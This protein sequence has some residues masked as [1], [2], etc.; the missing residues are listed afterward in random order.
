MVSNATFVPTRITSVR[1]RY[2]NDLVYSLE[3]DSGLIIA[4][5]LVTHNCRCTAQAVITATNRNRIK[6]KSPTPP[7][8]TPQPPKVVKQPAPRPTEDAGWSFDWDDLPDPEDRFDPE[9]YRELGTMIRE[10]IQAVAG[11]SEERFLSEVKR[12]LKSRGRTGAGVRVEYKVPRNSSVSRQTAKELSEDVDG[13]IPDDWVFLGNRRPVLVQETDQRAFYRSKTATVEVPVGRDKLGV[14]AGVRV[15]EYTHHLQ[16]QVDGLDNIF[17]Q[18]HYRRTRGEKLEEIY[19]GLGEYGRRDKYPRAYQGKEYFGEQPR[20]VLT[21]AMEA[22][23]RPTPKDL[24]AFD[25]MKL[26]RHNYTLGE[27]RDK[28]PEM[29]DLLLGVLFRYS[30]E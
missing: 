26:K 12:R 27:M 11:T 23:A 13:L 19:K 4:N 22:L 21:M 20:E 3:T 16:R 10:D 18:E 28:D 14:N 30:P 1:Q 25:R 17:H 6:G 24:G 2:H 5:G 8:P 29:M 15:H 7:E 9:Y